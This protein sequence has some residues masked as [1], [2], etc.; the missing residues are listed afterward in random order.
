MKQ[1][2]GLFDR[3]V[4]RATLGEAA[5]RAA[6]GKRDR[7]DVASFLGNLDEELA[8]MN[9]GLAA[10]TWRFGTYDRF[11]VRDTKTRVIH[12]PPFRDR[13]VHHAIIAVTGP[14]FERGA[15]AHSYACRAGRGHHAA[16]RTARLWTR[17]SD[18]YGK[19]DVEKFY[20]SVDHAALAALL[21]RRF[22]EQRLLDL[23]DTLLDSY[24]SRP[25]KGL[26]IGALTS[27]YLGNFYL[28][29]VDRRVKATGV[30]RYLRYMD[31]MVMWGDR[32]ELASARAAATDAL[33]RLGLRAKYGGEW[34]ACRTGVPLLGFVVFPDRVR[35]GRQGRRRLRRK[36]RSLERTGSAA[37][38]DQL[39]AQ[40]RATSIFAHARW[41]DDLAWRR[42]VLAQSRHLRA[43]GDALEPRPRHARRL[44]EQPGQ[45][46]PVGVSQQE[47]PWQP[48]QEPGL[49]CLSGSRHDGVEQALE[50]ADDARSRSIPIGGMDESSGKTSAGADIQ[51]GQT[52]DRATENASAGAPR[53]GRNQR[54]GRALG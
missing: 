35:L 22:R 31:D 13:V 30:H 7:A 10:G 24:R 12:A 53:I 47:E 44:L 46:L 33:D 34:N 23:L 52:P 15:I 26:P 41:A 40:Q 11:A 49:S 45:E 25:G 37:G 16:L 21:A 27:Q 32:A 39:C 1:V 50:P 36:I 43:E 48:Q 19:L 51:R 17:R 6:T 20:D 3:I 5:W 2:G 28:D 4:D 54:P 8:A 38:L 29:D 18:W 9:A 14:V 42:V